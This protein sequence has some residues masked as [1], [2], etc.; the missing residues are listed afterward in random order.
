[1]IEYIFSKLFKQ[2]DDVIL[3]HHHCEVSSLKYYPI[4]SL[5]SVC[6]LS[7]HPKIIS[8]VIVV[9]ATLQLWSPTKSPWVGISDCLLFKGLCRFIWLTRSTAKS[10]SNKACVHVNLCSLSWLI[11]TRLF[12]LCTGCTVVYFKA[13]LL[14]I[15]K[16]FSEPLPEDR[17]HC[18]LQGKKI[19]DVLMCNIWA[20]VINHLI[21]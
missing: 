4:I 17:V 16:E 11:H 6:R 15:I 20:E 13:Q 21:D 8:T 12:V 18:K 7:H 5:R 14:P 2:E 9:Y 1:M 19:L 3:F 10:L